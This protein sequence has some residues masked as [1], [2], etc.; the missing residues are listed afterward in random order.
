MTRVR[1]PAWRRISG[2][3]LVLLLLVGAF[4]A[5]RDHGGHGA[6][7][8]A[9][10]ASADLAAS[11][12]ADAGHDHAGHDLQGQDHGGHNP[13]GHA[14]AGNLPAGHDPGHPTPEDDPEAP[15]PRGPCP[16]GSPACAVTPVPPASASIRAGSVVALPGLLQAE[17]DPPAGPAPSLFRPPR[18][19]ALLSQQA[20]RSG[21]AAPPHS[22]TQ[23]IAP[24]T[25]VGRA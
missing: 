22:C 8:G 10:P 11:G 20:P 12:N 7:A 19:G 24:H 2:L 21:P 5:H 4:P 25:T 14:H 9:P 1:A 23:A 16:A 3:T 6:H 17:L 18:G 13:R 15:C